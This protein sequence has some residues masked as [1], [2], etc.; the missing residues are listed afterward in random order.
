MQPWHN[1]WRSPRN[2]QMQRCYCRRKQPENGSRSG[3]LKVA[4]A[5]QSPV[6]QPT[7]MK[8]AIEQIKKYSEPVNYSKIWPKDVPV[9]FAGETHPSG[10]HQEEFLRSLVALKE[11][12]L[13]HVFMEA[14]ERKDQKLI[15]DYMAGKVSREEVLKRIAAGW[16]WN[17][18]NYMKIIDE[19]KRLGL[20]VAAL[21][22]ENGEQSLADTNKDWANF[23]A[24]FLKAN[25]DAR[26]LVQVGAAHTGYSLSGQDAYANEFLR[27]MGIKAASMR[28]A[29]GTDLFGRPG[30]F[31]QAA[32]AAGRGQDTFM[33]RIAPDKSGWKQ[34]DWTIH[35]PQSNFGLRRR[36]GDGSDFTPRHQQ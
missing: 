26:A 9:M 34:T 1:D 27:S 35:V 10:E 31:E 25:P 24:D 15:D 18:E 33:I 36:L 7:I 4:T 16:G 13:T 3:L 19:A 30:V 17:P 6:S 22:V 28:Y 11:Q 23:I 21:R 8:D 2:F 32:D 29:G 20:K 14:L 12:G 5:K